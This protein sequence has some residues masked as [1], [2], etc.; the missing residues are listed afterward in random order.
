MKKLLI[1]LIL[2]TTISCSIS[3][4]SQNSHIEILPIE[5]AIVP[6]EF[7]LG[8]TYEI[9]MTYI[10][11]NTCYLFSNI[12]YVANSNE[13]TVAVLSE[14]LENNTNCQET[15]EELEVSFNFQALSSGSIIFKFWQGTNESDED[16]YLTI[17]V[18]VVN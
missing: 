5:S 6:N 10:K 3:D 8:Q 18:P 4:D 16:Q 7:Q 1:I 13:R 11:P 2:I 15:N 14:V 17:E 12:Y 9:V